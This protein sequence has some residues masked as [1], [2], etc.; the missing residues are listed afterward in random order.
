MDKI[1]SLNF[2]KLIKTLLTYHNVLY[3][4]FIILV[5]SL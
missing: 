1:N 2:K 3:N 5:Y 4:N